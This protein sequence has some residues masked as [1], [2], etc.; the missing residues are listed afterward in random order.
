MKLSAVAAAISIKLALSKFKLAR[1]ETSTSSTLWEGE[2]GWNMYQDSNCTDPFFPNYTSSA[3]P[4]YTSASLLALGNSSLCATQKPAAGGLWQQVKLT[5]NCDAGLEGYEEYYLVSYNFCSDN[6]CQN[7]TEDRRNTLEPKTNYPY[8]PYSCDQ[9]SY[10]D[11][12]TGKLDST[13]M[14]STATGYGQHYT[15]PEVMAAYMEVFETTCVGDYVKNSS[16]STE[17]ASNV[18][19]D[20]STKPAGSEDDAIQT[21]SSTASIVAGAAFTTFAAFMANCVV[22]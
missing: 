2:I 12:K 4:V 22:V 14:G 10:I 5:I 9:F 1:A 20:V 7:C 19:S 8:T 16:S 6:N 18:A 21:Q 3:A 17:E 15:T 11:L 13:V